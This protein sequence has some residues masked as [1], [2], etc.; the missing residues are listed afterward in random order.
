MSIEKIIS[1]KSESFASRLKEF[2]SDS[3]LVEISMRDSF[4]PN[5][6]GRLIEIEYDDRTGSTWITIRKPYELEA[7]KLKLEVGENI[8][9]HK[10][11]TF[12]VW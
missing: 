4:G 11:R 12:R 9:I 2:L 6:I 3:D 7:S 1:S 5:I 8:I 10:T